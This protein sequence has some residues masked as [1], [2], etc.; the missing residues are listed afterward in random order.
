MN[1]LGIA[2]NIF[3]GEEILEKS[4]R[5]I[6][7]KADYICA[8]VQVKSNFGEIYTG[9][10]IEV[11]R[12]Y[13][14]G[15]IDEVISYEPTIRYINSVEV[16]W[17]CGTWN[18]INKRNLGL[19]LCKKNDCNYI[20]TMDT[21]EIYDPVQFDFAYNELLE[22]NADTSFCQMRTYFKKPYY[23][24]SPPETYYVPFI[25][26]LKKDSEYNIYNDY[27]VQVDQTRQ[28]EPKNCL[29]FSRNEIE[30]HHYSYVRND[31]DRKFRNSS[32]RFPKE[33]IV[34][35]VKMFNEWK[36][37]K[38][39]FLLGQRIYDIKEVEPLKIWNE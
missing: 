31:I 14:L 13:S 36:F 26:K 12:L 30:M 28:L 7:D 24:L 38:K 5:S 3:D 18:E 39:A 8:V 20:L 19:E 17:T 33:E 22:Y 27:P 6:R 29:V 11:E 1:K 32:S 35:G 16:D 15:L 23:E 9:G 21:D 34:E 2:Y 25:C 37:G 10:N 4:L